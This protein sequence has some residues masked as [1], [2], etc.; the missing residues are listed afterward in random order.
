MIIAIKTTEDKI[1]YKIN[2]EDRSTTNDELCRAIAHLEVV[3][4]ELLKSIDYDYEITE[5]HKEE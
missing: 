5:D 2:H 4:Q 3:K 1:H